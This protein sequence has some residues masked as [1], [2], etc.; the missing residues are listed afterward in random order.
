[1]HDW[2]DDECVTTLERIR[3]PARPAAT[4]LVIEN[5]I[6]EDR[7]DPRGRTLDIVMLAV[8]GRRE[9][10]ASELGILFERAGRVAQT[11]GPMRF[12]ATAA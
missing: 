2:P 6:A 1:M 7:P 8:T 10:T 5:V 12:E 11:A 4:V 3:R 9:R